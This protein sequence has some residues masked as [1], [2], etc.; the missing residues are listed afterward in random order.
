MTKKRTFFNKMAHFL[1]KKL[2]KRKKS[3]KMVRFIVC[4][5]EKFTPPAAGA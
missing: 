4:F 2:K 5:C 3:E 1:N